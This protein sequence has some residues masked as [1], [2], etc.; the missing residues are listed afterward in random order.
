MRRIVLGNLE[1]DRDR[2]EVRVDGRP[3]ELSYIQFELLYAL[4]AKA[5]R[6]INHEQLLEQIWGA[7]GEAAREDS[8][9][10]RIH[11]S[12]LRKKIS[13]SKPWRIKTVTKRGYAL[14]NGEDDKRR[15]AFGLG[16]APQ[17][18]GEGGSFSP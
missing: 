1:L 3:I 4:A 13:G 2:Y 16:P 6:L 14:A 7:S 15:P 10:L 17:V 9:K 12:R 11:I 5:G 8:R 18:L